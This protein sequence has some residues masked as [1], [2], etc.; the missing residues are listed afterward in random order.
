[1][2]SLS[3]GSAVGAVGAVGADCWYTRVEKVIRN[4]MIKLMA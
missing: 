3:D 1:V 2:R 4:A